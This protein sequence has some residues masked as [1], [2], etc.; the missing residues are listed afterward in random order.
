MPV[1]RIHT[2]DKWI[3][4]RKTKK[5]LDPVDPDLDSFPDPE[6][7]GMQFISGKLFLISRK[8]DLGCSFRIPDPYPDLFQVRIRMTP[9]LD[10]HPDP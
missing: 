8:N 2:S 4:I 10:P 3:R 7:C 1:F 6:H 5:H 9:I